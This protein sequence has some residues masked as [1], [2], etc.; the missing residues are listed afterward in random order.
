MAVQPVQVVP[1]SR[2]VSVDLSPGAA[3]PILRS[4]P[5][6]MSTL[7]FL[8][9]TGAPW[10]LAVTPRVSNQNLFAAEW[11]RGSPVVVVS[12]KT[13]Y[14][15]G[16]LTVFLQGLVTPVVIK[17][18][19][20]EAR[21]QATTR[22]VDYRL[23]VRVPGRG[24]N[25]SA[26]MVAQGQIALYDSTMQAFLDGVPPD[27]ANAVKIVGDSGRRTQAWQLDGALYLRT[28]LGMETAFDQTISAADGTSVYKLAPTPYV[29]LSE[30]GHSLRLQLDID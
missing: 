22:T 3:A 27:R 20:G 18:A 11:L 1:E 13:F 30:L 7:V 19:T 26:P 2:S 9:S 24:P 15:Q 12:A 23:D 5:G 8:D 25:A 10:P 17:L 4:M 16:N 28:T 29:M 21:S 6:E 14:E